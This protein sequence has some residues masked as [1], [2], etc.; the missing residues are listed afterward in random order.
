MQALCRREQIVA[1]KI[2]EFT[3]TFQELR[4]TG[5][6]SQTETASCP[7]VPH[8]RPSPRARAD[9]SGCPHTGRASDQVTVAEV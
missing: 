2:T 5:D 3:E 4:I 8:R 7:N 1:S 9:A 6:L